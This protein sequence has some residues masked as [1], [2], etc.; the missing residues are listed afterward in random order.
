MDDEDVATSPNRHG[1]DASHLRTTSTREEFTAFYREFTPRLIA[2]L[3]V[4]GAGLADAA[5][6]A[7]E[8]MVCVF[9]KWD[10]VTH[11]KAYAQRAA[12]RIRMRRRIHESP[13]AY[14]AEPATLGSM[15][16]VSDWELRHE[17]L[18]LIGE[19][20]QRQRQVLAWT[21]DGYPPAEIA[22]MLQMTPEAVRSSLHRAR[23]SVA[24]RLEQE[25]SDG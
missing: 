21:L 3:L 23:R 10:S 1:G 9:Q 7:Q 24:R 19:L 17:F 25:G 15:S 4:Q 8:T 12:V 14:V 22:K 2:F 6:I 20:P 5:D 18:R 13:L 11:P 16:N